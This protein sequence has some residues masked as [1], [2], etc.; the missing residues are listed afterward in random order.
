MAPYEGLA[1]D[2][3]VRALRG[4]AGGRVDEKSKLWTDGGDAFL[5]HTGIILRALVD[6]EMAYRSW[7]SAKL[8][9]L[10]R[11]QLMRS[12]SWSNSASWT[13]TWPRL[14]HCSSGS[15]NRSPSIESL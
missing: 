3:I 1:P 14:R 2:Q 13:R 12:L 4:A 7:C 9:G 5:Y 11:A 15:P 8:E 10:E 6:H